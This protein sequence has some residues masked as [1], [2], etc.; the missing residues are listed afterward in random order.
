MEKGGVTLQSDNDPDGAHPGRERSFLAL[1]VLSLITVTAYF[2]YWLYSNLKELQEGALREGDSDIRKARTWYWIK[3]IVL[4]LVGLLSAAL[5]IP[6]VIRDPYHIEFSPLLIVFSIVGFTANLIFFY[7]FA[8][9]VG[10]AQTNVRLVSFN[11]TVTFSLYLV[12]LLI[13]LFSEIYMLQSGFVS[14]IVSMSTRTMVP[15]F[16]ALSTTL[17]LIS[18]SGF[19]KNILWLICIYQV[20]GAINRIW[21]EGTTSV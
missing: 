4:S 15:D 20:Q 18:I 3:I 6:A 12:S 10:R 13:D 19:V 14:S 16:S 11:V 21:R 5:T 8:L 2:Y 7:Y 9:S 1:L 17:T